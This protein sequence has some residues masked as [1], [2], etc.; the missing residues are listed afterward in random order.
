MSSH[1]RDCGDGF[2]SGPHR[3][4]GPILCSLPAK[5]R[6]I[7]GSFIRDG[8]RIERETVTILLRHN[9]P[10]TEILPIGRLSKIYPEPE[11]IPTILVVMTPESVNRNDEWV[12]AAKEIHQK[13]VSEFPTIS[14]E[15]IDDRLTHPPRYLPVESN[16]SVFSKWDAICENILRDRS[17]D[18]KHWNGIS[19]WRHGYDPDPMKNRV[20]IIIS[21][22]VAAVG[23]SFVTATRRIQGILAEAEEHDVD[24][25]FQE[26]SCEPYVMSPLLP[27][28]VSSETKPV[29]GMSIGICNSSA[30]SST[31]G[32]FIELEFPGDPKPRQYALTCFHSVFAPEGRRDN[33]LTVKG[34][35]EG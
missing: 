1:L 21:V 16:H 8:L 11:P 29:P 27:Y 20:T 25:L 28:S 22:G 19:C 33:L 10:Y 4:G 6:F 9:M 35:Q 34:A 30:G 18:M 26:S 23:D 32:G 31:L 13:F 7:T 12:V 14:V 5:C 17:L 24:I 15:I 3:A 2:L